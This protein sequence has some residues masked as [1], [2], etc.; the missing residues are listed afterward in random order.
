MG[1]IFLFIFWVS[2]VILLDN[3]TSFADG[4]LAIAWYILLS[5]GFA[6]MIFRNY[7]KHKGR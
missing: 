4:P 3:P 1:W 5:L 2:G 7:L 6:T